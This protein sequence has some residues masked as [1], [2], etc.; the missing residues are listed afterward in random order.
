MKK[1]ENEER[2]KNATCGETSTN[3]QT[4]KNGGMHTV[5]HTLTYTTHSKRLLGFLFVIYVITTKNIN[6]NVEICSEASNL[7]TPMYKT[8]IA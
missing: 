3:K 1:K 8:V 2:E 7:M 4:K 6:E 5:V